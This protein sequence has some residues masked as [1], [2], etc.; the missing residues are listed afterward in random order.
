[1]NKRER[2]VTKIDL[3]R[4]FLRSFLIQASWSFDRMQSLGFA[5]AI[6]PVLRRLYPDQEEYRSRLNLHMEYFNT[7]PYLA[8]FILGATA[9]LEGERASGRNRDAD[10]SGLKSALMAPLGAL[11]DSFFWG[12]LTPLAA[13]IAAAMLM[14]GAW[15]APL[16]FLFLYNVWHVGL[17]AAVFA[18]GYQSSGDAVALMARYN[19]TK[20]AKLFKAVSLCVIGGALAMASAWRPE[21]KLT[22]SMPGFVN[23]VAGLAITLVLVAVLRKGG[24]PVKLMLGLAGVCLALAY[25]GVG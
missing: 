6:Q 22:A 19:F 5:Y 12:A 10:V 13:V 21:L 1:M 25:L 11:G 4:V 20:M 16:L 24:S 2:T 3:F 23:A 15:W 14:T 7:Q 8:A 18:W 17:R 9:R